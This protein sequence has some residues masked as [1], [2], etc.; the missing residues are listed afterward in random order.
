VALGYWQ[1]CEQTAAAFVIPPGKSQTYYRTGDRVSRPNEG[2]PICYLGRVDQQININGHRVELG[3]VESSLRQEAGV[4]AAGAV[5]WPITASGAE[6][7]EAFLIGNNLELP[8]IRERLKTKLPSFA[9]PR[10]L[11]LISELP[12]N[13]NGKIDRRQLISLLA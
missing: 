3:E 6:G 7:I 13:S 4:E 2:G 5:G 9:V 10:R 11:H 8:A 1:D 12:L